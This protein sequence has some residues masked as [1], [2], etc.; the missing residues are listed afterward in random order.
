MHNRFQS[1]TRNLLLPCVAFSM[2]AGFASAILVT[3]FKLAA[4]IVIHLSN[5]LYTGVRENPVWLPLLVL[6]AAL[7]GFGASLILSL[8]HSCRGG[9]IPTSVTAIRGIISLKWIA[10]IFVLPFSALLTFFCGLPLGT[11]GPCVQ[12]GTAVGDGVVSCFG[13]KKHKGWRRYIMTGGASAGFSIATSAPISGILFSME[14]LH[15]HFSPLLLA[16]ASLSVM[17]AEITAQALAF[18]GIGS[19]GLFHLPDISAIPA[20]PAK[21]YFAP[22][23]L[24]LIC[25]GCSIFFTNFYVCVDKWMH[26]MLKKTSVKILFPILFAAVAVVGFFMSDVLG[27]GHALVDGI[28]RT[29]TVWYLLILVFFLRAI[30]M[31]V[32]NTAGTTGGIFLPTLAFGAILGALCAEGMIALGWLEAEQYA[33]MVVLGIAAFLG[34]ASR[35]P[36]TAC[37]FAVEALGG[38][39]NVLPILIATTVSFLVV[40][41]YGLEDFTDTVIEANI[42]SIS[43]G[44]TP[45]VIEVPLTVKENSFVA[46]KERRDILWPNAC[47]VI[48]Y[49]RAKENRGK[50][51]V[52]V[53]DVITVHYKTRNPAA[54]AEELRALVGDQSEEICRMMVPEI[55]DTAVGNGS[56]A[57]KSDRRRRSR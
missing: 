52:D 7:V 24:G 16:V 12:M 29:R 20:I 50:P 41:L 21:M 46:G 3:V 4:E 35:I 2:A 30:V 39:H 8:S 22:L 36:L 25:G 23:L 47:V 14:E 42:R 11:E 49:E 55:E 31:M 13:A 10:S 44:K 32:S 51:W 33:L 40:E 9:G 18:L 57:Q 5:I 15:K 56:I 45:T 54:A 48:S 28:L 6:G 43:K 53:G 17:T 27:T 26:G 1:H 19:V 37:V 34:A 38:I